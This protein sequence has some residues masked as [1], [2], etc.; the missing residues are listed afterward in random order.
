MSPENS[1]STDICGWILPDGS[2]HPC[3]AWKHVLSAK[4]IPW[5][6]EQRNKHYSL[7]NA[8]EKDDEEGFRRA[9]ASMGLV[10]INKQ[11]VDADFLSN[12]QLTFMQTLYLECNPDCELEFVGR[13][14]LK[15]PVRV[16]LKLKN[17]ERLNMLGSMN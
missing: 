9:L 1:I 3:P 2:W 7:G 16:F 10:K 12:A 17:P 6:A 15:M 5:V 4:E 11:F 13:I 14:V 8:W